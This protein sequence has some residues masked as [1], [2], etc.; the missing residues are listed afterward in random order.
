M[1]NNADFVETWYIVPL[2]FSDRRS[3]PSS[4]SNDSDSLLMLFSY[5]S[6]PVSDRTV[7]TGALAFDTRRS[8]SICRSSPKSVIS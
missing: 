7:R 2:S 3:K 8:D 5:K 4:A 6:I 1:G